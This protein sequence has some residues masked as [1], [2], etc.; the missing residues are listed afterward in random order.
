MQSKPTS[1]NRAL[2]TP[3]KTL[4]SLPWLLITEVSFAGFFSLYK[5][6][7]MTCLGFIC[8]KLCLWNVSMLLCV[9]VV[10][11][12]LF[13]SIYYIHI[14]MNIPQCRY[15]FYFW[16]FGLF[17]IWGYQKECCHKYLVDACPY[18]LG[19]TQER[20]SWFKRHV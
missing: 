8:S 7:Y 16:V 2:P 14:N 11:V 15:L 10:I 1:S 3:W 4:Q 20:D 6:N 12:T 19:S 5:W 18:L 17:L 9:A 13:S